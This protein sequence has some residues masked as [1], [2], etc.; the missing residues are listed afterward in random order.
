[1]SPDHYHFDNLP[2]RGQLYH[3]CIEEGCDFPQPPRFVSAPERQKHA[4]MHQKQRDKAL[5][6]KQAK[7]LAVAR[8]ALKEKRKGKE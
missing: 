7:A 2:D 3:A 1:M 8:A 6:E 5:K 4:E